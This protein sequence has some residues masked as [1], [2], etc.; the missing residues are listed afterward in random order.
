MINNNG[1][2][3]RDNVFTMPGGR[4]ADEAIQI[5]NSANVTV[6]GNRISF[7]TA[8]SA[9]VGIRINQNMFF[10]GTSSAHVFNNSISTSGLGT[11]LRL[12]K[13]APGDNLAVNVEQNDFNANAV[14]V[15]IQGDG[16]SAGT[17]DLGGGALGSRG[18][19]DFRDFT[20]ATAAAGDFAIALHNTSAAATVSA[21]SNIW[22]QPVDWRLPYFDPHALIK[23]GNN[24]S[25]ATEAIAAGLGGTEPGTGLILVEDPFLHRPWPHGHRPI[26]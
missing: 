2:V 6:A 20:A 9:S 19:N 25:T 5:L 21:W 8:D 12:I 13:D 23:D 18:R 1:A 3:V 10:D 26:F 22:H 15:F 17:I 11:G 16:T 24:N 14:G 4:G 7:M